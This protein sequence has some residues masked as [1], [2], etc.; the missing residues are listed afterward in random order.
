MLSLPKYAEAYANLLASIHVNWQLAWL[1]GGQGEGLWLGSQPTDGQR[2]CW[3]ND[4]I[5]GEAVTSCCELFK[6]C[7]KHMHTHVHPHMWDFM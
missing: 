1:T 6:A 7:I 5:S 3:G 2:T 4:Q